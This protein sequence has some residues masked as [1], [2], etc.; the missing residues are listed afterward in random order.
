[1]QTFPATET[2][3]LLPGP[4]GDLELLTTPTPEKNPKPATAIICHPHPLHGGTMNNKVVTTLAKTFQELGLKT[5]RFNF[6]GIGKSVGNYADGIGELEDLLTVVKWVKTIF[7]E[8]KIWLAGFS[9]GA[10]I[11][12]RAAAQ[13]E[14]AQ[15]VSIAPAVLHYGLQDLPPITA[16]WVIVQGDKDE[17]VPPQEVYAWIETLNPKPKLIRM[18]NAGHFFHGQLLELRQHLLSVL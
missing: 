1:M 4:V 2:H 14:V 8:D 12:I 6:R 16:P 13:M 3:F 5:V 9:F 18:E 15:L 7:P 10:S 11:S 17:V